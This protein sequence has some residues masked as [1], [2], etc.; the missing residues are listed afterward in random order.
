[1]V[2]LL[3]GCKFLIGLLSPEDI[4]KDYGFIVM[5]FNITKKQ[6]DLFLSCTPVVRVKYPSER[7]FDFYIHSIN[8]V[9]EIIFKDYEGHKNADS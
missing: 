5:F 2:S 4:Q 9:K 3:R 7:V 1:M 6:D 8:Q